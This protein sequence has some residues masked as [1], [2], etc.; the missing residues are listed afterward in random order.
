MRIDELV[1]ESHFFQLF[2]ASAHAP[3]EKQGRQKISNFRN[4][5]IAR[6]IYINTISPFIFWYVYIGIVTS[7]S[8]YPERHPGYRRNNRRSKITT[9]K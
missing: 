6:M 3:G 5:K 8:G 9:F 4:H 2:Y 7:K 1:V